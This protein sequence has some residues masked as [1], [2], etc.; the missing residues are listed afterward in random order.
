MQQEKDYILKEDC[1]LYHLV[2]KLE[3]DDHAVAQGLLRVLIVMDVQEKLFVAPKK[4]LDKKYR[5]FFR[6]SE[7]RTSLILSGSAVLHMLRKGHLGCTTRG[8]HCDPVALSARELKLLPRVFARP[9]TVVKKGSDK[10]DRLKLEI[11]RKMWKKTYIL[12][13]I[14]NR[15]FTRVNVLTF[16]N[17]LPKEEKA[18]LTE[19]AKRVDVC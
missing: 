12:V 14:A 1:R 13:V 2:E 4:K 9:D 17:G 5:P 11:T 19:T 6:M 3:Q 10:M 15:R 7:G 18:K 16:Y 8:G